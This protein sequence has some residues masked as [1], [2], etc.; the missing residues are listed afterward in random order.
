MLVGCLYFSYLLA[1]VTP[2]LDMFDWLSPSLQ[3][4]QLANKSVLPVVGQL[5]LVV[6]VVLVPNYSWPVSVVSCFTTKL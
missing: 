3:P 4:T 5:I 1:D 2:L 6:S